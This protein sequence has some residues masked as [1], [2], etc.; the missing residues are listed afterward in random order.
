MRSSDFAAPKN[1]ALAPQTAGSLQ[2]KQH[3]F[4]VLFLPLKLVAQ[5]SFGG[6]HGFG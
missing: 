1:L 4:E 3:Q 2:G 6:R 5:Y